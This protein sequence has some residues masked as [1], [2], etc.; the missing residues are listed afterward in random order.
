M[1]GSPQQSAACQ[2]RCL[3]ETGGFRKGSG[4]SHLSG[5]VRAGIRRCRRRALLQR[6]VHGAQQLQ[7]DVRAGHGAVLRQQRV[8]RLHHPNPTVP[9]EHH[10]SQPRSTFSFPFGNLPTNPTMFFPP[11]E[12]QRK[13]RKVYSAESLTLALTRSISLSPAAPAPLPHGTRPPA[14]A[15]PPP[16]PPRPPLLR[17]AQY[18]RGLGLGLA[19]TVLPSFGPSCRK[20]SSR[21][22][23]RRANAGFHTRRRRDGTE[24]RV[25]RSVR[26]GSRWLDG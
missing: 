6:G 22:R 23:C 7:L 1:D 26:R 16:H 5:R 10:I 21:F 14:R 11:V 24:R 17:H 4:H 19:A 25:A 9:R 2:T 15:P 13:V 18:C 3:E 8:V 20:R 12:I